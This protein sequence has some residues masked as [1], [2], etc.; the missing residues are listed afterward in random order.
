MTKE[1]FQQLYSQIIYPYIE[2]LINLDKKSG[3]NCLK[4]KKKKV[5]QIFRNYENQ[6]KIIRKFF[7]KLETKPMD[8]HKI[9]S[10]LMYSILKSRV[11]KITKTARQ[12]LPS[13]LLMANEYLA[14]FVALNIVESYRIDENDYNYKSDYEKYCLIIPKT[15]HNG[16]PDAYIDNLCK[17]LYYLKNIKDFDIFAY[18]NILF[19]LETYT[20]EHQAGKS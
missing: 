4:F 9:G 16:S 5:G 6:R 7:M 8:R 10:V 3:S 20:N 18:A 14:V 17:A 2:D 13:K 11:F 15:F 19:L 12:T 1:C